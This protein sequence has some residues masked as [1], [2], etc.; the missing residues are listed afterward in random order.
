MHNAKRAK[1][2]QQQHRRRQRRKIGYPRREKVEKCEYVFMVCKQRVK[3]EKYRYVFLS[4]CLFFS[5]FYSLWLS[6]ERR[7]SARVQNKSAHILHLA[8]LARAHTIRSHSKS[9]TRPSTKIAMASRRNE[10]YND[11]AESNSTSIH[12]NWKHLF[13]LYVN[14]LQ[15]RCHC[16]LQ[17]VDAKCTDIQSRRRVARSHFAK[18]TATITASS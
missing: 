7:S 2:Q 18:W 13:F 17:F 16:S 6:R 9:D 4:V 1:Q 10:H 14:G 8:Q 11:T 15:C 12:T 3:T 5:P